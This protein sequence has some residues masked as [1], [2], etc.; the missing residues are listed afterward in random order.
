MS[1]APIESTFL[2]ETA[3][4][5]PSPSWLLS[6]GPA[7]MSAVALIV[8]DK[9]SAMVAEKVIDMVSIRPL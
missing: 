9:T 5:S 6:T 3:A 1:L 7:T 2:L 4:F 8:G